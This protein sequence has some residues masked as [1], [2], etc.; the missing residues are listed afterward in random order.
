MNQ[1]MN[2]N[3]NKDMMMNKVKKNMPNMKEKN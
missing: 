2:D 3:K 1:N